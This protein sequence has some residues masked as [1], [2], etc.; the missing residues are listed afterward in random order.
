MARDFYIKNEFQ[1]RK[2]G[3]MIDLL[4]KVVALKMLMKDS[5]GLYETGFF[6]KGS[7]SLLTESMK[8][9]LSELRP[10]MVSLV[11]GYPM[12]DTM[13]SSIGNK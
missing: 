3:G 8:K 5:E 7:K 6:G 10:H 12:L 4:L 11:E 2:V 13:Y 1:D 9:L